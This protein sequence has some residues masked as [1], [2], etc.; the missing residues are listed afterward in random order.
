MVVSDNGAEML[1]PED[2]A[3]RMTSVERNGERIW[4]KDSEE[5]LP[6]EEEQSTEDNGVLPKQEDDKQQGADG[7]D[8]S[9]DGSLPPPT[10]DE[11]IEMARQGN[12]LAKYQLEAQGISWGDTNEKKADDEN[13]SALA[14]IPKDNEGNPIYEQTDA[15]TAWDAI[16]EQT[17]GDEEMALSVANSMVSDKEKALHDVENEEIAQSGSVADKIAAA[18]QHK[19]NVENA[20]AE[21][22]HWKEIAGTLNRRGEKDTKEQPADENNAP[23][24]QEENNV[25][26]AKEN[27]V[28]TNEVND[29]TAS[30]TDET[31]TPV[32]QADKSV[33]QQEEEN[34]E[35]PTSEEEPQSI[36]KGA[37]GNIYDQFKGKVKEALA[38]IMKHKSG[39]LLGVF[40][41]DNFGDVD[42]VWGSNEK[43]NGL[44]HIIEKHIKAHNDF[45]SVD[46]AIEKI[47][48]II[49]NGS[50]NEK[51]IG[52]AHV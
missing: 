48:D 26:Q 25:P 14:R 38:F 28:P 6:T 46:D 43:S 52:R 32:E 20:K 44:D 27:N 1:K 36:G 47:D 12:E 41:R 9:D 5:E 13:Q 22:E 40:H 15:D 4:N 19:Q 49:K 42:L 51:K 37:F 11:L 16:M 3:Q 29:N 35:A 24:T 30:Q 50:I 2:I 23:I 8:N 33:V 7:K 17:D 45:T 21:L 34:N 18:K 39:D 10:T 31:I